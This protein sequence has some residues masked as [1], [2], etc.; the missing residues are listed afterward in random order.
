MA[1]ELA[2]NNVSAPSVA[3]LPPTADNVGVLGMPSSGSGGSCALL[4]DADKA[5]LEEAADK[6]AADDAA[7]ETAAAAAAAAAI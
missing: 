3:P 4:S 1:E 6:A 7:A 2:T 5:A